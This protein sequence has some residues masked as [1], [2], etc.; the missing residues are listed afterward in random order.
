MTN[1]SF[2]GE[3]KDITANISE[4]LGLIRDIKVDGTPVFEVRNEL[5]GVFEIYPLN[6]P[7]GY[8]G[9]LYSYG[10]EYKD[11]KPGRKVSVGEARAE[12]RRLKQD[13]GLLEDKIWRDMDM[14]AT[15]AS[16]TFELENGKEAE[17]AKYH[18]LLTERLGGWLE[19]KVKDKKAFRC[20]TL[21]V[22]A[23]YRC[24]TPEAD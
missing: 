21:D 13:R 22:E 5:P 17:V 12:C 4:L 6:P 9:Y 11:G 18:Q 16:N 1:Y 24:D 8:P 15:L 19:D 7:E 10:G 3:E 14:V 23:A 20:G 2:Y